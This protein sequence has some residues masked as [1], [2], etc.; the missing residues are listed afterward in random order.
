MN[1][2]SL[3]IKLIKPVGLILASLILF[4]LGYNQLGLLI[5]IIYFIDTVIY[6]R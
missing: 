1:L 5:A 3:I 6:K 2:K 4:L